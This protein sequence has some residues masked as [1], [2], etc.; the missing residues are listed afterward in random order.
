MVT[1]K[2]F[3]K[4]SVVENTTDTILE[5]AVSF[6]DENFILAISVLNYSTRSK[7]ARRRSFQALSHQLLEVSYATSNH[8]FLY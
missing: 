1:V 2:G 5:D 4:V 8:Y 6:M 3:Q 7:E